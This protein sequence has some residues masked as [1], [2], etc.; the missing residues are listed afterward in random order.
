MI[1]TR[2]YSGNLS[3]LLQCIADTLAVHMNET[4]AQLYLYSTQQHIH[5][6]C[7]SSNQVYILC[8]CIQLLSYI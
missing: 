4:E 2:L 1:G 8:H 6:L 7:L 3:L 5:N